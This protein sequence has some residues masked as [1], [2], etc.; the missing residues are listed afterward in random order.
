MTDITIEQSNTDPRD[1]LVLSVPVSY[2]LWSSQ[3]GVTWADDSTQ[4][5]NVS[6]IGCEDDA[7]LGKATDGGDADIPDE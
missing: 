2:G 5:T 7:R 3:Y 6:I 1:Q 4:S